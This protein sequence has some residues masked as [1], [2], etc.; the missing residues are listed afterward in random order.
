M[1]ASKVTVG[2]MMMAEAAAVVYAPNPCLPVSSGN[3]KFGV[4]PFPPPPPP[5]GVFIKILP[6]EII[7][8]F[9]DTNGFVRISVYLR[10]SPSKYSRIDRLVNHA[11]VF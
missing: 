4:I 3:V 9:A 1:V 10:I 2:M 5:M 7:A 11:L 8:K 6:R